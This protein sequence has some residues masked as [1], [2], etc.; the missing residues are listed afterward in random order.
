MS[1]RVSAWLAIG[2]IGVFLGFCCVARGESREI[3]ISSVESPYQNGRQEIRVLLPDGYVETKR[4]RVLYVLPV[5]PG[6]QD[7]FGYG[8]GTLQRMGAHNLYDIIIVQMGFEKVPWFGDHAS[9]SKIRQASFLTEFVVPFIE[10]RYSTLASPE[11]RLLLGFS[12]S[13]WGAFSLLLTYPDFFGYAASWDAPL[14]LS[15]FHFGMDKVFGTLPQL[16]RYRPDLLLPK[17]KAFF[18]TKTRLVLMGENLWGNMVPVETGRSHTQRAHE[19]L[20]Q[21]GIKHIYDDSLVAPHR[22]DSAWLAPVLEALLQ[23]A[24]GRQNAAEGAFD[25]VPAN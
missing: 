8:L 11:G 2:R 19:L 7:Q 4:Y 17:R 24:G 18:R 10:D 22:W 20:E 14:C 21:E 1:G 12:K 15:E 23:I 9:D 5:E 25:S 6:F 3:A 16:E 13:G